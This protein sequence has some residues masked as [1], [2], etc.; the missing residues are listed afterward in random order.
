MISFL[1]ANGIGAPATDQ[2][3]ASRTEYGYVGDE[4]YDEFIADI[5]TSTGANFDNPSN[6]EVHDLLG[7]EIIRTSPNNRSLESG[8]R[9]D[10]IRFYS[11]HLNDVNS[12][13]HGQVAAIYEMA[14]IGS[15]LQPSAASVISFT[16]DSDHGG[17]T[18]ITDPI[19]RVTQL[20]MDNL[21]RPAQI[22]SPDPDGAGPL[23]P[24]Q[25]QYSYDV[26]GNVFQT[27]ESAS[28]FDVVTNTDADGDEYYN[29]AA[30]TT[31]QERLTSIAFD[32]MNRPTLVLQPSLGAQP[33]PSL[34]SP[35][36]TDGTGVSSLQESG[37]ARSTMLYDG[38]GQI[39][40]TQNAE[41]EVTVFEYDLVGRT[42]AVVLP[43]T[44]H[45]GA[46]GVVSPRVEY[47]FYDAGNL[48][49]S[50]DP[51]GLTT[52]HSYDGW[53]RTLQ[54]TTTD[55]LN[56][57][58]KRIDYRYETSKQTGYGFDNGTPLEEQLEDP[59]V[60]RWET[61]VSHYQPQAGTPSGFK[62]LAAQTH[63]SDALGRTEKII[64]LNEE[65]VNDEFFDP[66]IDF[67]SVTTYDYFIDHSL[68]SVKDARGNVTF[69][70]Y[71]D[72]SRLKSVALPAAAHQD[73]YASSPS[74]SVSLI[75]YQYD[76][77]HQLVKEIDPTG[78]FTDYTYDNLGNVD[79]AVSSDSV[80]AGVSRSDYDYDG[81]SRLAVEYMGVRD[82]TI[83]PAEDHVGDQ[84][85]RE[86]YAFD[87]RHRTTD[88]I[89]GIY[90]RRQFG[91]DDVNR[92]TSIT[93]AN[94]N[95]TNFVFDD[96]GRM[97]LESTTIDNL[98]GGTDLV[99]RSFEFDIV[100]NLTQSV[101]RNGRATRH[102]YD[103]LHNPQS[104]RWYATLADLD[105]GVPAIGGFDFS[106][107]SL[108]RLTH[109]SDDLFFEALPGSHRYVLGYDDAGRLF[110]ETV[111]YAIDLQ[112]NGVGQQAGQQVDQQYA[113]QRFYDTNDNLKYTSLHH[114]STTNHLNGT[115]NGPI[116][117][118]DS[119]TYDAQNRMSRLTRSV[120]L[121]DGMVGSFLET[122]FAYDAAGRTTHLDRFSAAE[123][124]AIPQWQTQ[125]EYDGAGR[126]GDISH[127]NVDAVTTPATQTLFSQYS[128][129]FSDS[130]VITQMN[131]VLN[132]AGISA[133]DYV[134]SKQFTYDSQGQVIGET[135][136]NDRDY[137][138]DALG[139]RQ[140][141]TD[142]ASGTTTTSSINADNRIGSSAIVNRDG[143]GYSDWTFEYDNEGNLL[144]KR[145]AD[146]TE[147]WSY[148][149]D[150]RNRLTRVE[151]REDP[152]GNV[153]ESTSINKTV[154][155]EYDAFNQWIGRHV[156]ENGVT[157]TTS[158]VHDAG[159]ISLV[160]DQD[161]NT[162]S[163]YTWGN[164]VDQ[165]LAEEHL[166]PTSTSTI[167]EIN[168]PLT[169]HLGSVR[170]RVNDN[171]LIDH[172]DYDAF[173][174][175]E[176]EIPSATTGTVAPFF[177]YTARPYDEETELQNNLNRWYDSTQGRWISQDPIAFAAGD[178]S[179]YRYVG[180]QPTFS[181]DPHGLFPPDEPPRE[182][183]HS[184][185]GNQERHTAAQ[186]A[187]RLQQQNTAA[188]CIDVSPKGDP[189]GFVKVLDRHTLALPDRPGNH[190]FD[191]FRNILDTGQVGLM[192]LVPNRTEVVRVSGTAQVVRDAPLRAQMAIKGRVPDFAIVIR[193]REAFYNCGKAAI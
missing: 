31:R 103:K 153:S 43:A 83:L 162:R 175:I 169:D 137:N 3:W 157:E 23:L 163:R 193:V 47:A 64:R 61:T 120:V 106:Y 164:A 39:V 178:A 49:H 2:S 136:A 55:E 183:G 117:Y 93:D 99:S 94:N 73:D 37:R 21:G 60:G 33:D 100:G 132:A 122:G 4:Q 166:D 52:T 155:H 74:A 66:K 97:V 126:I 134:T 7:F 76:A 150:H 19:G 50:V 182:R 57:V 68:R 87:N 71:D 46:N 9:P 75:E 88:H 130:G 160:L 147:M 98:S 154:E 172:R 105:N 141:I 36:I 111:T 5:S 63:V 112:I 186:R 32:S 58:L 158:F 70:D 110:K 144:E 34:E 115:F 96:L 92:T 151:F 14:I 86:L 90:D 53:D 78:R 28:V 116:E 72:L 185:R 133:T 161:G 159:Q 59:L 113:F 165:L 8:V 191:S 16:Y 81:F 13:F 142:S 146:G 44:T 190:R 114:G 129:T 149:W 140:S 45:S 62:L 104:E 65:A 85:L 25:T 145:R 24:T 22:L 119:R 192:F 91:Y 80:L 10:L 18:S 11:Y 138:F 79:T 56:A 170:D 131:A 188:G 168:W 143:S 180:N 173:G 179:L 26:F 108:N 1:G 101:D 27:H 128:A 184:G 127:Y 167:G 102:S 67:T 89:Q 139:N 176:R 125:Y 148:T 38:F 152:S 109:V 51:S 54:S 181:S 123:S 17:L 6:F 84:T 20:R 69:Y 118:S 12:P 41:S 135:G 77:A 48:L 35:S 95:L 42:T 29:P 171:V 187:R 177:G 124:V 30:N 15:Q 107:D 156:T 174:N 40:S 82:E 121:P 189:I